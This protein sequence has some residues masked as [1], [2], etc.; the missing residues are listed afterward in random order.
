MLYL[1]STGAKRH[2]IVF[3]VVITLVLRHLLV[4]NLNL[5]FLHHHPVVNGS[6]VLS[7]DGKYAFLL[8]FQIHKYL[9]KLYHFMFLKLFLS[10]FRFFL[11]LQL[12]SN[13]R[14]S[15]VQAE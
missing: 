10:R 12:T 6:L 9:K 4:P 8:V 14:R 2:Y 5:P 11:L 1:L 3:Y 13:W 7:L 15:F